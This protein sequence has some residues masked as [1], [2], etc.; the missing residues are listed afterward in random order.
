MFAGGGGTVTLREEGGG[1]GGGRVR[2]GEA[3]AVKGC[4]GITNTSPLFL[5][6]ISNEI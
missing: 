4:E 2:G 5:D 3:M 6:S 1:S